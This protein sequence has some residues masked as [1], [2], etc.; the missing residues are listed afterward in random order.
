MLTLVLQGVTSAL[1]LAYGV[2][3]L[4]VVRG[5]SAEAGV[6][7]AAWCLTGAAFTAM[8]VPAAFQDIAAVRAFLSG[9]GTPLY[10]Q[11]L[12][13]SPIANHGR[14]FLAIAFHLALLTL[15]LRRSSPGLQFWVATGIALIGFAVLGG[16]VGWNE[17]SVLSRVHYANT[18][19]LDATAFFILLGALLVALIRNA[20]DRLLWICM[21]VYALVLG[22]GVL[23]HAAL[24]WIRIPG[25]WAPSPLSMHIYRTIMISGMVAIAV[26]RL[27]LLRRGVPVPGLLDPAGT[28]PS[29]VG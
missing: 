19:I 18:S 1:L 20:M 27:R 21:V 3:A 15:A 22:L 5:L 12:R 28:K 16:L 4:G 11:Y 23:W 2:A 10:D 9:P 25:A 7:R 29:L 24:A 8:A 26:Y 13:W 17:G 6:Q 14:T